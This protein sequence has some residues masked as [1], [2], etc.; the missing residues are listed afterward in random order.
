M[1]RASQ[2]FVLFLPDRL[3]GWGNDVERGN[4][5]AQKLDCLGRTGL[6]HCLDSSDILDITMVRILCQNKDLHGKLNTSDML[7][8]TALHIACQRNFY[9]T[10]RTL[11]SLG[12][13]YHQET[14]WGFQPLHYA[15][16][17]GGL[18]T[19]TELLAMSGFSPNMP[20]NK[21]WTPLQLAIV[22]EQDSVLKL[23]LSTASVDKNF[24]GH[25]NVSPLALAIDFQS[26][27]MVEQWIDA[28]ADATKEVGCWPKKDPVTLMEAVHNEDIILTM[29]LASVKDADINERDSEG[30]TPFSNAAANGNLKAIVYLSG[31]PDVDVN[32][33]DHLR[34]T[35]LMR[36]AEQGHVNVVEELLKNSAVK[37]TLQSA[38]GA[39]AAQIAK[40]YDHG[41]IEELIE[42]EMFWRNRRLQ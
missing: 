22:H 39:S 23:L 21:N 26:E 40:H 36:A 18:G 34:Y 7:G 35:P 32:S 10:V 1:P 5:L 31:I 19:C 41:K 6:H 15:A 9:L 37:L 27:F 14:Q 29:V 12:A 25:N 17:S 3:T 24:A 16:A 38:F 28:G 8:R 11:L 42:K 2:K 30:S 33:I 4:M 20:E 13:D